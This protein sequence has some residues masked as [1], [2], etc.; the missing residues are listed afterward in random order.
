[1][2]YLRLVKTSSLVTSA[3]LILAGGTSVL[4]MAIPSLVFGFLLALAFIVMVVGIHH[5]WE[6]HKLESFLAVLFAAMYGVFVSFNYAFQFSFMER[7]IPI[8]T[9]LDMHNID[10]IFLVIE[11][12]GYFFM[13]LSTLVLIPLFSKNWLGKSIQLLFLIN[14]LLGIG[15]LIGYAGGWN[16]GLLFGGLMVWNIIMPIA[17]ALVFFYLD[18]NHKAD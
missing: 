6:Q 17:A 11:I 12:L 3:L 2:K 18:K 4:A 7:N 13:G 10:S 15:G 9:L 8:P 14:G 5:L 1:M 16:I